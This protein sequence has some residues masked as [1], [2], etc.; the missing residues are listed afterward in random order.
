MPCLIKMKYVPLII[1]VL[2]LI[3]APDL[4]LS[5]LIASCLGYLQYSHFKRR[6]IKLPLSI[7]R[8]LDAILPKSFTD[9]PDFIKVS[10]SEAY[11]RG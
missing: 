10:Q 6:F 2:S 7:Y 4:F 11:L 8:K 5:L 9:R 3:L 1:L